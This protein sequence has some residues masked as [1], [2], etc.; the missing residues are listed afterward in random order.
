VTE[1]GP[2]RT[3][4]GVVVAAAMVALAYTVLLGGT[5]LGELHPVLR[6]VNGL[7]AGAAIAVYLVLAPRRYDHID[8][9]CLAALVVFLVAA[10]L[11][12]FPRQ[13]LDGALGALTFAAA[14]FLAR[15]LTADAAGRQW[16]VRMLVGL[17]A[18]LTLLAAARWLP[19]TIEWWTLTGI[20]PPLDMNRSGMLWGHRHDLALV[21][22][23]LYPAWWIGRRSPIRVAGAVVFGVLALVVVVVDG[24][25]TNWLALVIGGLAVAAPFLLR[26]LRASPRA[27]IAGVAVA[28]VGGLVAIVSGMAGTVLD[29]LLT[30]NTLV[31]RSDMWGSLVEVWLERPL[32]GLGP[33]SFP[34]L[35]QRS[36][37]FDANSWA[38]R[39]PDS[40]PFQVLPE[41]GL[42]GVVAIGILAVS[43]LPAILRAPSAARFALVALAAAGIGSNP[44]EFAFLML[45]AIAWA[46]YAMP[47]ARP[48]LEHGPAAWTR[49]LALGL[50]AVIGIAFASTAVAAVAH[51]GARRSIANGNVPEAVEQLE[52]AA[53]LDPGLAMYPRMLGAAR[54]LTDDAAGAVQALERSVRL[55]PSDDLAWRTLAMAYAF[56]PEVERSLPALDRAIALQR[57]DETNLLLRLGFAEVLGPGDETTALAAELVHGWPW[58]IGLEDWAAG[59]TV[60]VGEALD[61]AVARLEA[62]DP[63]PQSNAL[64]AIWLASLAQRDDL[65]TAAIGQSGLTESLGRAYAA[66]VVCD[67]STGAYLDAAPAADRRF[68]EYWALRV[69]QA[70]LDG[71]EDPAA[72]RALEIMTGV[73]LED[74]AWR[75]RLNPLDE[76]GFRGLSADTWGYRRPPVQWPDAPAS[77][78]WPDGASMRWL[79]DPAGAAQASGLEV[80]EPCR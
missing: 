55:N 7:L 34:W 38:P 27:R 19:P 61:P 52:T 32:A 58:L 39:H 36:D 9:A 11:S 12:S 53:R 3:V 5:G 54:L 14:F 70:S 59:A 62:V 67:P 22:G 10:V 48:I 4:P 44:T 18:V 74:D 41:L 24:S 16:L 20:V 80:L 66:G 51:D 2:D 75:R 77:V 37:Y 56:G 40:L 46:A 28:V 8:L 65:L 50:L 42:L 1:S 64:Y 49:G 43:L 45:V 33:G 26:A 13:S 21:V 29:R 30:T 78:P 47:N 76:N 72:E 35:L 17:S 23:V 68:D 69:R 15:L 6:I 57:S 71:R 79:L 25:R 60:P 73:A 31:S 63:A